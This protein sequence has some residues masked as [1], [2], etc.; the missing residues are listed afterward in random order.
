MIRNYFKIA[1]RNL[2]KHK[3][4]SLINIIGL[5]IGLSASFVIGLMIYYDATF[6]TFHK[7]SDRIYRVV[8][9]FKS[10]DGEFY[11][12]G[13]TLGLEEAIS[14]NSNFETV[15]SFYIERPSKVEN[16]AKN[17]EFKWPNFVIFTNQ[18]YFNLFEYK[19]LAGNEQQLLTNPNEVILTD[20]RAAD[21]FPDLAPSEII[22]KTL[23]YNDSINTTVTGIVENFTQRT[24]LVFQE[25]IS[26]PTLLQTRLKQEITEKNWSSTNSNSQLYVKISKTAD[27]TIIQKRLDDLVKEHQDEEDLK[28]GQEQKFTLQ[29]LVDIHFNENY[30]TYD[31]TK[32]QASKS[33]LTNLALVA[34]F[35]LLLG[36]INFINLNTAQASQRAKEI[37][38]RKTLGSSRKQLVGQFMGETFLLVVISAVLSLLLS[39]WLISLFSDFVPED[40]SFELFKTPIIVVG[41]ILILLIVTFLS[42]FY[43]ALIL[44][45]FNTVSVLKNHLTVGDK[46]VKLRK[47]LTV[48]QFTI[49]QIF[50]IATLLV[51]KQINYLLNKDM[52]FK[53]D[54]IVSVY[55][56]R[57]EREISKKELYAEKLRAIPEVK[58]ISLGGQ[59][60]ASFSTHSSG[61]T[62]IDGEKEINSDLQFIYGDK[63]YL[64]LFELKL[65]AGRNI[66]N[67]TIKELV[68]NETF[69]SF[70]GFKNPDEAIGKSIV[71]GE[72]SIPI[73][74]VMANFYQRS[75]KNDIK[76]MA[77][78]G[79]WYGPERSQFQAVH[80]AFQS[81]TSENLK[82]T[83]SKIENTYKSVYS[84]GEDY[85]LVFMD[86]TIQRFYNRERKV[87]KLL[88]WATGLSILISCLGLLGLVIYTTNRRVKEIGVRKVL[89]ASLIQINSLLCKEFLILV[90][91]AFVIASPIAWFGVNNWLQDF[92]Y[93]T[94]ISFWVFL[95]SGFAMICFALLVICF[96][97]LQAA[98]A[99]PVDS[100]RSE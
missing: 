46:K 63:N 67:D 27:L 55:S 94:N 58:E 62:Y 10:P 97:T 4:F 54:A 18:N 93:K 70:L 16:K 91:I 37:G 86:E 88:N 14:E 66:R 98:S 32:T 28:F 83:L 13:I 60:P 19:F 72:N 42:G 24:D 84:E 41:I 95:F 40:L 33:L 85:R 30:G 17:I 34:L 45:K 73:V 29:P 26:Q 69:R 39:N 31:W 23:V 76:P 80:I 22:G 99:N 77:L 2:M 87:S 3:V 68:I 96:K 100:L 64:H 12:S 71:I 47:F 56:P 82:T 6:D 57:G 89:G 51:G 61:F 38:I 8:T 25:F 44:S 11:N 65:L 92:A 36:C 74:G 20:K 79:D 75:L 48:F 52:G 9:D 43:P 1:W 35:L 21:Y 78:S 49:A 59:P 7:D 53:T 90:V 50:I 81:A 15:S 5:T